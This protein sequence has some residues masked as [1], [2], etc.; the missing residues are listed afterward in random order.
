MTEAKSKYIT[1]V[2]TEEAATIL[3]CTARTI[4]NMIRRG[5]IA[6]RMD[7]I[8]PNVK[9]GVLKIPLSEIKR[10]QSMNARTA[11]PA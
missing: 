5:S 9:K 4:R 1:E 3:N 6:A 11:T 7:K 8:D 10:I 2:T